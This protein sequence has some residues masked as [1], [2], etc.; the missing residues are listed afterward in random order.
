MQALVA[1]DSN[2]GIAKDGQIPWHWQEDLRFFKEKT[3]NKRII[4][5]RKTFETLP[6]LKDR[7]IL[8]LT[9][10]NLEKPNW[11]DHLSNTAF[12]QIN[13]YEAQALH[14]RDDVFVCGGEEVYR[15]LLRYCDIVWVC[16]RL[17]CYKCDK[18]FPKDI[19]DDVFIKSHSV[20]IDGGMIHRY[21]Y[22]PF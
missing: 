19:L 21:D 6:K 15:E 13:I 16:Q 22:V 1:V 3:L 5:G 18:F 2:W 14:W 20:A 8:C 17:G 4:V 9:R 10:Q 7:I 12:G 11:Y